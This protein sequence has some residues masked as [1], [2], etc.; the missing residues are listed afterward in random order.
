MLILAVNLCISVLQNKFQTAAFSLALFPDSLRSALYLFLYH[1]SSVFSEVISSYTLTLLCCIWF[2][3]SMLSQ[4]TL[5][6]VLSEG[7]IYIRIL[8]WIGLFV[9]L[10]LGPQSSQANWIIIY[11]FL[12]NP[13]SDECSGK[14]DD[15]LKKGIGAQDNAG[16]ISAPFSCWSGIF[17]G[18]PLIKKRRQRLP[19]WWPW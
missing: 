14:P 6:D 17:S 4:D 8:P 18:V 15:Y 19:M 5:P 1:V 7:Q 3:V 10:Y 11:V 9:I 16:Y 13:C 12:K 2:L